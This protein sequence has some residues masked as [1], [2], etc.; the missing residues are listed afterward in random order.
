MKIRRKDIYAII[1]RLTKSSGKLT[2]PTVSVLGNEIM[3]VY[4]LK[5]SGEIENM[6]KYEFSTKGIERVE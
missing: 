4:I 1:L 5:N 6:L 3:E 2:I